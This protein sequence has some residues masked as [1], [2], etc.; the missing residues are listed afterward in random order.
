ML[1]MNAGIQNSRLVNGPP[2]S[3]YM[4]NTFHEQASRERSVL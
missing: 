3:Q 1:D 2:D 4:Y